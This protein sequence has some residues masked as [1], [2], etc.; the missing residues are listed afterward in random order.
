MSEI[1][2]TSCLITK[3]QLYK[4]LNIDHKL[5]WDIWFILL[6]AVKFSHACKR[7]KGFLLKVRYW[8]WL[9]QK[10]YC[11]GNKWDNTKEF[12]NWSCDCKSEH[13]NITDEPRDWFRRLIFRPYSEFG[14]RSL[15]LCIYSLIKLSRQGLIMVMY[16]HVIL[17]DDL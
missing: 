4:S 11:I 5:A 10:W 16:N 8:Q 6:T 7:N 3:I 1:K 2:H 15:N 9:W 13:K 17:I 14:V 12:L